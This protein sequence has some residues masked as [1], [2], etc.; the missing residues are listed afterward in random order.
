[1]S[2][3]V[4]TPIWSYA[5]RRNKVTSR[6]RQLVIALGGLISRHEAWLVGPVRQEVL[7]GFNHPRQ[8]TEIRA[9]LRAFPDVDIETYDFELAAEFHN[10]CRR[11]GTQG[12][13]TDF[14]ICAVAVRR[15][16]AV[17]TNDADF[18][19]YAKWIGVQLYDPED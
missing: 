8:F 5:Y 2:V 10:V 19:H 15:D 11:K 6:E 13:S 7:T 12:S 16:A 1:L 4:D 14:L 17:F 3:L 9:V 18:R